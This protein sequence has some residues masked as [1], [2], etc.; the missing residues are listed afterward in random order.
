[1]KPFFDWLL[2]PIVRALLADTR[3]G[4]A[5]M[6]LTWV[7]GSAAKLCFDGVF[8]KF[9]LGTEK[10]MI[11]GTFAHLT[12]MYLRELYIHYWRDA[13]RSGSRTGE[14]NVLFVA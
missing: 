13:V 8:L 10:L 1:M 12:L 5:V 4:L 3:D 6:L 14:L 2:S 7:L 11:A 9:I